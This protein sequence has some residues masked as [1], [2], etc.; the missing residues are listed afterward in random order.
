MCAVGEDNSSLAS[1]CMDFCQALAN[2]GEA[3]NF[4]LSIGSNFSFSL[5]TRS[6]EGKKSLRTKKPSPSTLRRNARRRQ[7]YLNKKHIPVAVN[8]I[9]EV[10]AVSVAPLCD[11][12]DYK[13][14][15]EKGLKTHKRMKHGPPRLTQPA[16]TPS[17]P[18]NLRGPG[19]MK[20][21]FNT[22][23][24][25]LSNRDENCHNCG[26][27][28]SPSHQCESE[29]E[30]EEPTS[31]PQPLPPPST[32]PPVRD[33]NCVQFRTWHVRTAVCHWYEQRQWALITIFLQQKWNQQ[34]WCIRKMISIDHDA[35]SSLSCEFCFIASYIFCIALLHRMY[36]I[37]LCFSCSCMYPQIS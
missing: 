20:S 36:C 9:A 11:L 27:P 22:S 35:P 32:P 2:Q 24:L 33:C 8:Q 7:E 25:S 15:S 12:C 3:F 16:A 26:D 6:E 18:E 29:E 14:A 19:Q 30:T 5:D 34:I 10:V 37:C 17:S 13:A 1:K 4:S 23:P 21:A 28:F 31:P